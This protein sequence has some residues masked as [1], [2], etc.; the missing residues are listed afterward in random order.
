M[1]ENARNGIFE[2]GTQIFKDRMYSY[3]KLCIPY[4]L[5][6]LMID[7]HHKFLGHVG[8]TRLWNHMDIRYAW[9]HET[10]AKQFSLQVT[11]ACNTCQACQR[12][13]FLNGP[14]RSTPIPAYPMT[15]VAI[16]LFKLPMVTFEKEKY[17]TLAV[18]VDRQSGWIVAVPCLENGLTAK[19]LAKNVRTMANFWNSIQ[20][21]K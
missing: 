14:M 18:C 11:K 17:V 4:G 20:N 19:K 9:A 3:E 12:P 8:G 21:N 7:E 10:L 1:W 5:Q 2:E 16:D 15:S 13:R 6:D